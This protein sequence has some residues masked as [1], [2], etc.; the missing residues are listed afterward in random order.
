MSEHEA[1]IT[2][3]VK[4][5][6]IRHIQ[7]WFTDI[8]G[9]LKMVEI[10]QVQLESTLK[11]G[12]PFDGSSISGYAEVEESDIVAMPDWDT[13]RVLPWSANDEK[14]A[15]VFCDVLD[16]DF[17]PFK[18]DPRWILRRQLERARA[19]GLEFFVGPEV[20][21]FYFK[22]SCVPELVDEG[23][24]FAIYWPAADGSCWSLTVR[25]CGAVVT[26]SRHWWRNGWL[27][28]YH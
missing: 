26:T 8:V 16:R 3:L 27:R 24:Y 6:N 23:G 1:R 4:D 15:F 13:F 22:S 18:G 25:R 28:W 19:M 21:F 12:T 17:T 11:R 7:L 9:H 10:P 14:T 5:E 2:Q 20:E